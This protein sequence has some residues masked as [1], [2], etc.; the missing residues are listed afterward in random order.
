MHTY[1]SICIIQLCPSLT[2]LSLSLSLGWLCSR[3]WLRL[4][5]S[6]AWLSLSLSI[7]RLYLSLARSCLIHYT[8]RLSCSLSLA[9]SCLIP[10][11]AWPC[12]N[13]WN[14]NLQF[15][16]HCA[17]DII[18]IAMDDKVSLLILLTERESNRVTRTTLPPTA[19]TPLSL[20]SLASH[21]LAPKLWGRRKKF[22]PPHTTWE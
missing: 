15:L 19:E 17:Q 6:L 7:T 1:L 14:G 12:L 13:V 10:S 4:N 11:L 3:A 18:N 22:S 8:T 9:Q 20:S 2:R 16:H 21:S 5:L